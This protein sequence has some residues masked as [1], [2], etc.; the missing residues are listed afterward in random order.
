MF[1]F[2]DDMID[3]RDLIEEIESIEE[4][5]FDEDSEP[6]DTDTFNSY[7]GLL[8]VMEELRG[9]GGDEEWRG[10][11]YPNPLIRESYFTEYAMD[12][13]SDIG[14]LPRDIPW[15][16]EIDQDATANNLLVDYSSIEI[17]GITYYY[18]HD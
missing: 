17:D 8:S 10:A 9:N 11:W 3:I 16:I 14:D 1:N 5:L 4:E 18:R 2:H 15:Y 13:L 7:N 12:L 6:L